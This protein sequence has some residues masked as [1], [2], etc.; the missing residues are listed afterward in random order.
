MRGNDENWSRTRFT[1]KR[2]PQLVPSRYN[3]TT[4]NHRWLGEP[5]SEYPLPLGRP[6]WRDGAGIPWLAPVLISLSLVLRRIFGVSCR[7][8]LA[9]TALHGKDSVTNTLA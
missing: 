2:L 7:L 1:E 4:S 3:S 9:F 8:T 5:V 6:G